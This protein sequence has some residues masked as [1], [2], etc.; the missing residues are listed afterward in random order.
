M[1]TRKGYSKHSY[2]SQSFNIQDLMKDQKQH[3][4]V[5]LFGWV[6]CTCIELFAFCLV[7]NL[8][9]SMLIKSVAYDVVCY[10]ALS[11]FVIAWTC[12]FA[13]LTYNEQPKLSNY[14]AK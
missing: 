5:S 1:L 6:T 11:V 2:K 14:S 13:I 4:I 9:G 10:F 3:K 12:L 7:G 8:K